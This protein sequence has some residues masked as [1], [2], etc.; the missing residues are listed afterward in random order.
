LRRI[1][2]KVTR[3]YWDPDYDVPV[4]KPSSEQLDLF[5]ALKLTEPGDARP[6]FPRDYERLKSAIEYDFSSTRLYS[7][8]FESRFIL[9]NKVPY[10]DLMWEV[11]SSDNVWGQLY[12]DPFKAE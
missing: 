11:V 5:Y 4:I 8:W 7:E 9:L 3:I 12:Y 2:P 10:W 1:W 6:G